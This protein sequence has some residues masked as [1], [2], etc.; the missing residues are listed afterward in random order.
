LGASY[1]ELE[2]AMDFSGDENSLSDR[3]RTVLGIYKRFHNAN[4]HKMEPIPVCHLP[5]DL[6][7]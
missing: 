2:W 7:S 6:L 5:A 4:K 3:Q 1:P